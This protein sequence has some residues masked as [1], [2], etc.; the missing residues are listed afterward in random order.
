MYKAQK[1]IVMISGK[2]VN[3]LGLSQKQL[4]AIHKL[5]PNVVT[6]EVSTPKPSKPDA[7]PDV[8]GGA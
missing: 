6:H 3:L 4:K 7:Q 2:E 1:D 5:V 8:S